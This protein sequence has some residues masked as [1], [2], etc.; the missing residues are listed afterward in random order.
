MEEAIIFRDFEEYAIKLD[1]L[2]TKLRKQVGNFLKGRASFTDLEPN[3]V[4]LRHYNELM[5]KTLSS[6]EGEEISSEYRDL[7]LTLVE[8]VMTVSLGEERDILE[9]LRKALEK[10]GGD[11]ERK[12]VAEALN[13]MNILEK[14]VKKIYNSLG[15][16]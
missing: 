12:L 1:S 9:T 7:F 2:L 8:F 16:L 11:K 4:R 3:I 10:K 6:A 14:S 5:T 15:K 13:E